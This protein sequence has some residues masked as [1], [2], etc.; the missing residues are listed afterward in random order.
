M[1]YF[2]KLDLPDLI[3]VSPDAGGVERARAY[4][5]KLDT[6]LAIIDKRRVEANVAEIVH[7]VGEVEGRTALIVDDMIDTAGTLVKSA[8]AL[9]NKGARKFTRAAAIRC[10]RARQCVEFKSLAWKK[11]SSRIRFPSPGKPKQLARSEFSAWLNYWVKR[12]KRSTRRV[13]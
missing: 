9:L 12:S 5:K 1:D 13:Q 10:F 2:Q 6:N 3:V 4:A 7:I 11:W 8:E